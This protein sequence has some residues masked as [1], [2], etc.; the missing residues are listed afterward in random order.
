MAAQYDPWAQQTF[1]LSRQYILSSPMPSIRISNV[2][3]NST[4]RSTY[5]LHWNWLALWDDFEALVYQ[6]WN[7]FVPQTDK[8]RNVYTQAVYSDRVQIVAT[9]TRVA[10]EGNVKECIKE[11]IVSIHFVAVNDLN[12]APCPIDQH[13]KLQ[14]WE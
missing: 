8:Q 14:R 3:T 9:D 7:N 13:S 5:R 11:F 12:G 6:Y 10:N 2:L 4:T 1:D